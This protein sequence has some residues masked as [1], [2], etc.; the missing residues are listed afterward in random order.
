MASGSR[1]RRRST[2]AGKSKQPDGGNPAMASRPRG[3]LIVIANPAAMVRVDGTGVPFAAMAN[4]RSL[5][6][7][8]APPNINLVPLFGRPE[9]QIRM[10]GLAPMA[11]EF[12]D[13]E[14]PAPD[15]SSFYRIDAPPERLREL[16]EQVRENEAFEAAYI[17]PFT[18]LP[19]FHTAV[20]TRDDPPPVTPDFLSRQGY[21]RAA[22]DGIDVDHARTFDGGDGRGVGII[23]IEGAWRFTHE[24]LRHLDGLVG[25]GIPVADV[26]WRNHGTAVLGILGGAG[27]GHGVSGI[28]PG[29]RIRAISHNG[30]DQSSSKAIQQ[31]AD[32]LGPG[33]IILLEA[34]RP[35]PQSPD[36]FTA[37]DQQQ[38]Y[39][40][41]EWWPDD[42]AA[43]VYAVRKGIVVVGAAGNG[44]TNLDDPIYDKNPDAA[45]SF[46]P[47]PSWW[48]NPFRRTGLNSGAVLVGAGAPPSGAFG[49]DRSR[50]DFSNHGIPVNVQGWGREVVTT[51]YGDLQGPTLFEDLW[52]THTFAGTSSASPIVV[53]SLACVQGALKAAGRPPLN[54]AR[55]RELLRSTGTPQSRR[56]G[57]DRDDPERIGSRP[58]LKQLLSAVGLVVQAQDPGQANLAGGE[59]KLVTS[60][61]DQA[62][63]TEPAPTEPV[64]PEPSPTEVVR[65]DPRPTEPVQPDPRPIEPVQP[66]KKPDGG[67]NGHMAESCLLDR[68]SRLEAQVDR[69][70]RL[71]G[72]E[73]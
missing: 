73:I 64:Q 5:A 31:A 58:D 12:G 19:F 63:Q 51:G 35:G 11:V 59:K 1:P 15:L 10:R 34:H 67:D 53:G 2:T 41:I 72:V 70:A 18:E 44:A 22:P 71:I 42:Y 50:L 54:S 46:G 56:T 38:G 28:C 24:S 65:P 17:K 20:P 29:A 6:D 33:D 3:E 49:P 39:I 13:T 27:K 16:A 45:S 48:V 60:S 32:L 30:P 7:T 68:V 61:A 23:D 4:T 52:Y 69:L 40:A 57:Q 9:E 21:L 36:P 62:M 47:F 8:F 25:G 37:N 26:D 43:I 14:G 66:K 55:A